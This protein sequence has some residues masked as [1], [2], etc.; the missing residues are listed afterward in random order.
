MHEIKVLEI[1]IKV[2]QQ[3]PVMTVIIITVFENGTVINFQTEIA[4]T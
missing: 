3:K 1:F 2:A 4:S